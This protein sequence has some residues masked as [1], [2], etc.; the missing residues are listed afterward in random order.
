MLKAAALS[1]VASVVLLVGGQGDEA[2]L[3]KERARFKGTWKIVKFEN[4]KGEQDEF[5]DAMV[6]FDDA[7]M[8]EMRK[9]DETKKA[10]YKLDLSAKPAHIDITHAD[11]GNKTMKG[12]YEFKKDV[13]K[14]C[15]C[16]DP[17]GE[18][19]T[20][21]KVQADSPQVLVTLERAK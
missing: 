6:V 8:L 11:D 16:G 13:L 18:R 9:G 20:G 14:I 5:K 3:K 4:A 15:L 21:L 2:K 10:D 1:F 7:S 12:V 17:N 19:P